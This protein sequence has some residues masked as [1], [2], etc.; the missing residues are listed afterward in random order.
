MSL[1][2]IQNLRI[3]YPSSLIHVLTVPWCQAIY[4]LSPDVDQTIPMTLGHGQLGLALRWQI[5]KEV[6]KEGYDEAYIL[7]NSWKSALIPFLARIPKRI[8][9]WGEARLGL[10]T[11]GLAKNPKLPLL[12][13]QYNYLAGGGEQVTEPRLPLALSPE[14][15]TKM[16]QSWGL[17]FDHPIIAL[18]PGAEYGPAKRWPTGYFAQTIDHYGSQG[19]QSVILGSGKDMI[20][21]QEIIEKTSSPVVNL[22][23][24]TSLL[25]AMEVLSQTNVVVTNDSGL[26]HVAAALN[27]PTVALF[28]SSSPSYTPP[29]SQKA[30]IIYEG[31]SCSPCF[32]RE[33]PL[34]E[35]AHLHCLTMIKPEQIYQVIAAMEI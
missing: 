29:L 32:K 5:A 26:M 19:W 28:G 23:G 8:G 11:H 21:A 3:K 24:Q 16:L 12:V 25:E 10:L 34:T 30:R 27:R 18:C 7:P 22:V 20:V 33:C 1:G 17:N 14:T 13:Q 15:K 6:K 31:V 2:L 35:A 4:H 9:Y